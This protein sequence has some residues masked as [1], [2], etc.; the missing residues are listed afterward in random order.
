MKTIALLA[1]LTLLTPLPLR[2]VAAPQLLEVASFGKSQPVG[3]AVS[4]Q[5]QRVFVSFPHRE[6][7]L[8]ALAEI[9]DGQRK[10]FPDEAW[11]VYPPKDPA[12]GFFNVQALHADDR[13]NLW[14]L[15]SAAGAPGKFKLL[16]IDLARNQ[17]AKIYD[18]PDLPKDASALNDV[19]VDHSRHSAY[20]SDPGLKAIVVLDL[21][22]GKSR[23][24]L[25]DDPSTVAAKD[26]VL[27]IED[28]DVVDGEGRPFVSN[29]NG[30]A[31]TQD[32]RWLYFRAI[33]QVQLYRIEVAA[34]TDP[35][36]SEADLSAKVEKVAST[37]VCHGMIADAKGN[38]YLTDSP[39]KAIRYVTPKGEL[40][41]LVQ[42]D[43]LIWPDSFGIG[44]DGFLYLT[45][46][47]I[48]RNA[49]FQGGQDRFDYP[50]RA[51]K[52]ALPSD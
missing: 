19:V 40:Q 8:C 17:V 29:V 14:V 11:N 2:A 46:A 49:R 26:F 24:V 50:F 20:L 7:Y 3:M 51:Y 13:N 34:L 21:E 48:N 18:F 32:R 12:S 4:S 41:T 15:D 9:V 28:R 36:L 42:D 44:S 23:I 37:G 38:I 30:I 1:L 43:R 25:R 33:C 52:V 45:A 22:T 5:P 27:R 10:P 47:Q 16:R 35:A 6:P 31:L 39:G